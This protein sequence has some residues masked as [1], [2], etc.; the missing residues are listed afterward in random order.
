MN[1]ENSI[2]NKIYEYIC[3]NVYSEPEK[4][5]YDT[6][7]FQEGFFDSMGFIKLITFVEDE[8]DLITEDTDF[9]EKNFE[10]I[11]A[12]ATYVLGKMEKKSN[13]KPA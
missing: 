13:P 12:I 3:D 5:Q 11:N 2:K 1:T 8:F 7:L 6:L 9:V 10:S 4:I